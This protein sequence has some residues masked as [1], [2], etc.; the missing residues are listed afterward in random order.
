ML[1]DSRDVGPH[2]TVWAADRDEHAR[3]LTTQQQ[4]FN[5]NPFIDEHLQIRWAM[6]AKSELQTDTIN[7]GA[8]KELHDLS[9]IDLTEPDPKHNGT[10][11]C[12]ERLSL[13]WKEEQGNEMTG[14]FGRSYLKKVKQSELPMGT[15]VISSARGFLKRSRPLGLLGGSHGLWDRFSSIA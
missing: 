9:W 5:E 10:A 13:I 6:M 4:D 3:E 12:N 8:S 11:M 7:D 2:T 14:L 1:Q 15:R